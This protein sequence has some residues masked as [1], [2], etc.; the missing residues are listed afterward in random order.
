[1]IQFLI[2]ESC[3]SPK[4]IPVFMQNWSRSATAYSR[5]SAP[6]GLSKGVSFVFQI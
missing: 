1:M 3:E 6:L 2:A 5:R 4:K